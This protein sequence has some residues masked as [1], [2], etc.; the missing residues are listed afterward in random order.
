ML[1]TAAIFTAGALL[2]TDGPSH[3]TRQTRGRSPLGPFGAGISGGPQVHRVGPIPPGVSTSG[4]K[5]IVVRGVE[6]SALTIKLEGRRVLLRPLRPDDLDMLI[7]GWVK[8]G[9]EAAPGGPPDKEKLRA[10]IERSGE[11]HDGEIEFGIE[12]DGRLVG[13][14]QTYRPRREAL[15]PGVFEFGLALYDAA[16]RGRGIGTEA[17]SLFVDWLFRQGAERIQAGTAVRNEAMKRVFEKLG[18]RMVG[19]LDIEGIAEILYGLTRAVWLT[20]SSPTVPPPLS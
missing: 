14:I 11:L 20:A 1:Y 8:L 10:R 16:D 6:R 4:Y 12:V 7:A 13:A 19:E 17:V 5:D 9:R 3:P 15:P 18:F 2:C